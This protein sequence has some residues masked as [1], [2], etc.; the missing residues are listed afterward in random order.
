M[1]NV[2]HLVLWGLLIEQRRCQRRLHWPLLLKC[3]YCDGAEDVCEKEGWFALIMARHTSVVLSRSIRYC[4]TCVS[5]YTATSWCAHCRRGIAVKTI[6]ISNKIFGKTY[7]ILK[8]GWM[9]S[10]LI[11]CLWSGGGS[12]PLCYF[13]ITF[14]MMKFIIVALL[15]FAQPLR[16]QIQ[17][18]QNK[19]A[20]H[21]LPN[22]PCKRNMYRI[23]TECT[24]KLKMIKPK[25]I[26]MYTYIKN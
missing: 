9:N 6:P 16:P 18:H 25:F 5:V 10:L 12:Y 11:S 8:C 19:H 2:G 21:I 17:K 7:F 4:E 20:H 3:T 22:I 24:L 23:Y 26:Y 1:A 13:N 14:S 15:F